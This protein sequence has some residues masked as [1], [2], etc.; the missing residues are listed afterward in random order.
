M[1]VKFVSYKPSTSSQ[2][3]MEQGFNGKDLGI[4]IKEIEIEKFKQML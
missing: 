3:L 1:L 4:K 2:L